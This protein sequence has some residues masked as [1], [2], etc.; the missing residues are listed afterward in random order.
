MA[1]DRQRHCRIGHG[2]EYCAYG[3]T[4]LDKSHERID[5]RIDICDFSAL[6]MDLVWLLS[7]ACCEISLSEEEK[8]AFEPK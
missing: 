4:D 2:H 3:A 7:D 8:D 1:V 6:G 5:E